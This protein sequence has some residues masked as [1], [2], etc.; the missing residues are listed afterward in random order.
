MYNL[1][2]A[3]IFIGTSEEYCLQYSPQNYSQ[4]QKMDHQ[5]NQQHPFRRLL[6]YN[7]KYPL[8]DD[9]IR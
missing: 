5:R 8:D 2:D 9:C 1:H 3:D 6:P 7:A 4:S